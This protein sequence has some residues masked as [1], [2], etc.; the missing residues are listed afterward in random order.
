MTLSEARVLA[1]A[2]QLKREIREFRAL[3]ERN[4]LHREAE[5]EFIQLKPGIENYIEN[6]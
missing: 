4:K 3:L 5:L 2:K 6:K 1:I